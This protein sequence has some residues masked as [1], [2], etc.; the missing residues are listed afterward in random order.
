MWKSTF[1]KIVIRTVLFLIIFTGTAL[2]V[3]VISNRGSKAAYVELRGTA[4]PVLFTCVDGE[5]LS[6]VPAYRQ[7][8]DAALLRD[9]IIPLSDDDHTV[10]VYL[11][12][13]NDVLSKIRYRLRN[14]VDGNLI[15]EGELSALD[16][17]KDGMTGYTCTFRMDLLRNKEYTFEVVAA[18]TAGEDLHFYTR[19]IRLPRTRLASLMKAAGDF[20]H[21]IFS[22]KNDR[23]KKELSAYLKNTPEDFAP[24]DLGFVSLQSDYDTLVWGELSPEIIGDRKI[25]LTEISEN[26]GTVV[27]RYRVCTTNEELSQITYYDVEE[28][29]SMEYVPEKD[30]SNV[31]NYFRKV[32]ENYQDSDFDRNLNGLHFG[33]LDH[34]PVYAISEDSEYLLFEADNSMWYYD[35]NASTITRIYGAENSA[36][37]YGR[38]QGIRPLAVNDTEAW[39]AV[40]GRMDSGRHEGENGLLLQCYKKD[41]RTIEEIVFVKTDI[42]YPQLKL[43]MEKLLFLDLERKK[44]YYLVGE[45]IR[46]YSF[47]SREE[48]VLVEYLRD[49]EVY[50]SDDG[51]VVAYPEQTEGLGYD[52]LMLRDLSDDKSTTITKSG[53]KLAPLAFVGTDFVYGAADPD[54]VSRAADGSAKYLF[55][56]VFFVGRSGKEEK[57]YQKSGVLISEVTFLSNTIYLTRVLEAEGSWVTTEYTPDYIS[58]K[59]AETR[60]RASLKKEG[61]VAGYSLILPDGLYLTSIPEHLIARLSEEE[62]KILTVDGAQIEEMGLLY[63]AGEL[64][65]TS[66]RIGSLVRDAVQTMGTV[67]MPDGTVLYRLRTGAPYLSV[68]DKVEYIK[69]GAGDNGYAACLSMCLQVAGVSAT[70]DQ[71][72]Q[73][74]EKDGTAAWEKCFARYSGGSVRGLNLSGA[75]LETAILY[76]GD[77]IPFATKL[78]DRYV[79]VVSFN[80]D[81]IRFYDPVRGYEIRTDRNDFRRRVVASGNEFY[82]YEKEQ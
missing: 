81:A 53:K 80:S 55:S 59:A 25:S 33:I 13:R 12:E 79:L 74:V 9:A 68:A 27:Y 47:D 54:R 36:F 38:S 58:Y 64:V 29:F 42:S 56:N 52:R 50:V 18:N 20:H 60:G 78:E 23:Q 1:G 21:M 22:E 67:R 19:V 66:S 44:L 77:G 28:Q 16:E 46:S 17:Q 11:D 3:N 30:S 24:D 2:I 37:L 65:D 45:S 6:P 34:S 5:V 51:S 32:R 49:T 73:D 8:M 75:N 57:N 4:L 39:F 62:G 31:I 7:D 72:E 82:L 76:L 10:T 70:Q 14:V 26:S 15:E 61:G 69:V 43:E 71:V 48:S 41:T 35:Y 63:R 40:Y